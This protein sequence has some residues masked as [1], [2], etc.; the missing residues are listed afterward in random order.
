MLVLDLD[1]T[2]LWRVSALDTLRLYCLPGALVGEPFPS[3]IP[4]LH[5]LSRRYELAAVTAR[6]SL[7]ARNT[8]A[9]LSLHGFPAI[10]CIHSWRPHPWD[11]SRVAFKSAAIARLRMAGGSPTIGV[12][13]RPSDLEAYL[14]SGLSAFLVF[15]CLR[16]HN[17]TESCACSAALESMH[18]RTLQ[19]RRHEQQ[20]VLFFSDC[21]N[22]HVR[23]S[24][25]GDGI[26][27]APR[28]C[29][30][31]YNSGTRR[32]HSHDASLLPLSLSVWD[33]VFERLDSGATGLADNGVPGLA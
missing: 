2:V 9:W 25:H 31:L 20:Q 12:G 19:I 26:G 7:A 17:S 33:Q 21:S 11:A 15:H 5:A 23:C 10:P 14:S 30:M 6:W 28:Y 18:A 8:K 24:A 13:D 4:V 29:E 1:D 16:S 27:E 3:A 32:E 22:V